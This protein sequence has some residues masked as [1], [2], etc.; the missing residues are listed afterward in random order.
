MNANF[1]GTGNG[2]V[3]YGLVLIVYGMLFVLM[4]HANRRIE[5]S[6]RAAFSYLLVGWSIGTFVANY[7]LFRAG[8]MSFL[9]W[10]NNFFHT[11]IWIGLCLGFLYAGAY[12][13]PF[14]EQFALFA[15]YSLI[16]KIAEHA[17]LGTW[18]H[19][20]FFGIPGNTAYIIGWSLMDGLYPLVSMIGLRLVAHVDRAVQP[21][22]ATV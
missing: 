4:R 1:F 15:I 3:Q 16:V 19:N 7:L 6:F 2:I 13:K 9:P 10:L 21:A 22:I 5:L 11:F 17:V 18:Q 8:V 14:I 20:N 12:R